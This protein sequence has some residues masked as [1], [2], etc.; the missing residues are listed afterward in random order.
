MNKFSSNKKINFWPKGLLLILSSFF[1]SASIFSKETLILILPAIFVYFLFKKQ[2]KQL[3]YFFIPLI[4]LFSLTYLPSILSKKGNYLHHF[5]KYSQNPCTDFSSFAHLYPDP[6]TCHFDRKSFLQQ[7]L[8]QI[9][10]S[11]I[12]ASLG[13]RKILQNTGSATIPFFDRFKLGLSLLLRHIFR[14]AS[15]TEIGGVLITILLIL[16]AFKLREKNKNLFNF[17]VIWI[18]LSILTLSFIVLGNRNHLMDWGVLITLLIVLGILFLVEVLK[19]R[20]K[21]N[22]KLISIVLVLLVLYNL[23][24]ASHVMWGEKYDKSFIPILNYY[25]RQINNKK[26]SKTLVVAVPFRPE[27]AYNLNFL[28]NQSIIVF[29]EETI[30]KLLRKSELKIAFEKFNVKYIMGYPKKLSKKINQISDVSIIANS[31][32]VKLEQKYKGINNK[33]WFLNLI[34]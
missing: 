17:F 18:S 20:I 10:N 28:T 23:L 26:I 5:V 16:G 13:I 11:D 19:E 4:L 3:L 27:D 15:I 9:G 30:K 1:V 34:K 31:E 24:L 7:R 22:K 2:F 12:M 14:F 33:N 8:K 25:A 21:I 29:K 6:Y 32:D